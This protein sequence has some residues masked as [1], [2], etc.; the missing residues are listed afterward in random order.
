MARTREAE[1]PIDAPTNGDGS[2]NTQFF[3]ELA[4]VD[5]GI[6]VLRATD[7]VK[8]APHV[9]LDVTAMRQEWG[10]DCIEVDYDT[11]G[12]EVRRM[13]PDAAFQFA[14][15]LKVASDVAGRTRQMMG[16]DLPKP[17]P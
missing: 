13:S 7:Y 15:D 6:S 2:E 9:R 17:A 5:G 4:N 11:P 16:Y 14:S 8:E 3:Q 12:I 10:A 1:R